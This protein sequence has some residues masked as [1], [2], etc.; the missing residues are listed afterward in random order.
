MAGVPETAHAAAD[1]KA[2][3]TMA[4]VGRSPSSTGPS[5]TSMGRFIEGEKRPM[6]MCVTY[7]KKGP[8]TGLAIACR[9]ISGNSTKC[10]A[11]P[12][13]HAN[14]ASEMTLI[15]QRTE[16]AQAKFDP[17]MAPRV[18]PRVHECAHKSAHKG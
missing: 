5:P 13:G 16:Q 7:L 6:K 18:A 2:T 3:S 11:E 12:L 9:G 15:G 10:R 17:R 8:A 4:F 14:R 1:S